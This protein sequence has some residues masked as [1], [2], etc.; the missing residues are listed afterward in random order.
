[1]AAWQKKEKPLT[2]EEAIALARSQ[3]TPFWNGSVPRFAAIRQP[4]GA[5]SVHPLDKEFVQGSWMIFFLDPLCY[6]GQAFAR[7]AREWNR[8]YSS[9]TVGSIAII[10]VTYPFQLAPGYLDVLRKSFSIPFALVLDVEGLLSTAF[11]AGGTPWILLLE[12]GKPVSSFGADRALGEGETAIQRFL[13]SHDPG[14]PLAPLMEGIDGAL[15]DI[16]RF[17]FADPAVFPKPGFVSDPG[18]KADAASHLAADFGPEM[19]GPEAYPFQGFRISGR[20]EKDGP[21][22]TTSDPGARIS[23]RCPGTHLSIIT[24][25]LAPDA[26]HSAEVVIELDGKPVF[27]AASGPHL[28]MTDEGRTVICPEIGK[29]RV[30]EALADLPERNRNVDLRFPGADAARVALYGIRAGAPFKPV[31]A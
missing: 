11:Q 10:R 12:A 31:S 23:F 8:R 18:A 22:I 27:D 20:W 16:A 29:V 6:D 3:L 15:R 17:D 1:M 28:E 24:E 21:R 2:E 7:L 9:K 14:L 19:A 4:G 25:S 30:F 13:R 5:V 26:A